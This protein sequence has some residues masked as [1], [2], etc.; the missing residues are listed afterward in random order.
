MRLVAEM[1][2]L[3]VMHISS[4]FWYDLMCQIGI[5][6]QPM[7]HTRETE[8]EWWRLQKQ[9]PSCW[10]PTDRWANTQQQWEGA[11]PAA[12]SQCNKCMAWLVLLP[13]PT[14]V[15]STRYKDSSLLVVVQSLSHVWLFAIPWTAACQDFLSFTISWSLPKLMSIESDIPSNHLVLCR[16]LLVLHSIILSIRVYSNESTL[17]IR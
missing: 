3:L 2:T 4:L 13:F 14:S 5:H 8:G 12:P 7:R 17:H 10:P 11:A 15:S 6:K 16:P 9:M 1:W